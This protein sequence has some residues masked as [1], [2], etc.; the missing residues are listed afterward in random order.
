MGYVTGVNDGI[1][2]IVPFSVCAWVCRGGALLALSASKYPKVHTKRQPSSR[3]KPK[4]TGCLLRCKAFRSYRKP[5]EIGT[6]FM[7]NCKLFNQFNLLGI[8]VSPAFLHE[9]EIQDYSEE[10]PYSAKWAVT[11]VRISSATL[12]IVKTSVRSSSTSYPG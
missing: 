6:A 9:R 7:K 1:V 11:M 4:L 5:G 10:S 12:S 8:Q 2:F 3:S